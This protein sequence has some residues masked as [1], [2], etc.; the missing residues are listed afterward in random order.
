MFLWIIAS[1]QQ[2]SISIYGGER[3]GDTI[4]VACSA[5]HTCP[6]SKPT[7]ILNGIEGSDQI[8]DESIKDG[9]WK[10]TLTRTGVVKTESLSMK[11]SVTHAGGI[12]VTATKDKSAE[13]ELTQIWTALCDISCKFTLN[14]T[15]KPITR[16]QF[17]FRCSSKNNDRPWT[18]RFHSGCCKQLCL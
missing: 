7:I 17:N 15:V 13:C 14:V 10:T 12:T 16:F 9:L 18:G 11:C 4:T 6:Y 3:T 8:K 1:P 5:F 2:P